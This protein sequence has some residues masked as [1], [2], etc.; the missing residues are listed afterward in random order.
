M[1][2]IV[3]TLPGR[4][5]I[6][7]GILAS[8]DCGERLRH[9]FLARPGVTEVVAK[10]DACSLIVRYDAQT[11][12]PEVMEDFVDAE[13]AAEIAARKTAQ[14]RG[15]RLNHYAKYGML[16]S[17]ALSLALAAR[18]KRRAHTLAGA[19]FLAALGAHLFHHRHRITD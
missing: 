2:F 15:T 13:V 14:T 11:I 9:T 6:R 4:I 12:V 10:P 18:G 8:T 17:L 16:L 5:R 7:H 3:S 1:A 19:I